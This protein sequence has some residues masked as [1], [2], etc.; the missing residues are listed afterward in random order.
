MKK[1]QTLGKTAAASAIEILMQLYKLP[2]VNVSIIEEWTGFTRQGASKVIHRFID[3]GILEQ[4][5]EN[6]VYGRSFMYRRYLEI[7]RD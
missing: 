4:K 7:F 1:I 2:V 6:Q 3:L 5:D